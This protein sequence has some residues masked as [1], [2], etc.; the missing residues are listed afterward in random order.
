VAPNR[1]G[2][3]DDNALAGLREIGKL[4]KNQGPTTPLTPSEPP[5]IASN[6]AKNQAAN[7]SWSDD[8]NIMDFANDDDFHTSWQAN[9][10]V[11]QPW[12]EI[13]FKNE[14]SFNAVVVAEQKS[15]ITNYAL[16]Y[17]NGVAWQPLFD[18]NNGSRIK[19]HRFARVWGSKVRIRI[20]AYDHQ[21][22]IAEFQ[23]FDERR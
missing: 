12:Y 14:R 15:N 1:D 18:G 13:D 10:T 5:I 8:M 11:S 23:V 21:P 6:I 19:L 7:S 20:R 4:W 22:S 2:L 3:I 16:D 17:W 9:K